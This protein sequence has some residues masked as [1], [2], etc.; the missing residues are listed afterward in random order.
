MP[1]KSDRENSGSHC[2]LKKVKVLVSLVFI[3]FSGG[4]ETVN[5]KSRKKLIYR[6]K[7]LITLAILTFFFSIAFLVFLGLYVNVS[8]ITQFKFVTFLTMIYKATNI[9]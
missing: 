6:P 8:F 9:Y 1:T 5:N 7:F 3:G 4:E 2:I